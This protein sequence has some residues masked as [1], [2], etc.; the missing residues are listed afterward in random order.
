MT[1]RQLRYPLSLLPVPDA[2]MDILP[3]ENRKRNPF[4][5]R[6]K[7]LWAPAEARIF[8]K[9]IPDSLNHEPT[10]L[11]AERGMLRRPSPPKRTEKGAFPLFLLTNT[12]KIGMIL[13]ASFGR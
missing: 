7:V 10:N 12:G 6:R 9:A 13:K 8:L 2:E 4:D 5:G 11:G 3:E 1:M